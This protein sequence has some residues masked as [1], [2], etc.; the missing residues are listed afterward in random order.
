MNETEFRQ[1]LVVHYLTRNYFKNK[2]IFGN[3]PFLTI[4]GDEQRWDFDLTDSCTC[5]NCKRFGES[6][7]LYDTKRRIY[8][9]LNGKYREITHN[10]E[11]E[12]CSFWN[13]DW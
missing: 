5:T 6:I 3:T 4:Y 2:E 9:L 13:A 8:C 7:A 12:C 1:Q 10:P 11:K